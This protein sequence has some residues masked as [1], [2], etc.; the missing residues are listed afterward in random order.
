MYK[1][2]FGIRR[3]MLFETPEIYWETLG[4]LAKSDGS[5]AIVWERNEEQGA[6]GSEGRIHCHSNLEE[7][8]L[9]LRRKFTRGRAK[10]VLHRIN[11][12]EFVKDLTM[13]HA[14]IWGETQPTGRIRETIPEDY[15]A[16]FER[17]LIR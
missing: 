4:F 15:L 17:G 8:T 13:N 16:D 14:F 12:N 11:C 10:K 5:I 3:K 1:T 2:E 6:W 7:F 9:P